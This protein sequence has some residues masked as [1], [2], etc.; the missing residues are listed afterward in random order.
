M[1]RIAGAVLA[2]GSGARMGRAKA[3]LAVD[4]ERLVDRAVRVLRSGGCEP[5]VA[6]VRADA[7]VP[8]AVVVV[9]PAPERGMR[10]SL[11]LAV[12]E[13]G[14]VDALAVLLVDVPGIDARAIAAVIAAWQP[15]RIAVGSYPGGRGHPTVMAPALWRDALA[16]AGRD[17]GAR[18][19]L[20]SR[21]DLVDEVDVA[22]DVADLDTPAD[23]ARWTSRNR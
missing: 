8:G 21:S 18:A 4:G 5:V 15:G 14:D 19:L 6:I 13:A 17:E 23:V 10:S 9:N 3:E 22:G 11:E 2:A 12:G 1:S 16:R 20:N 7:R